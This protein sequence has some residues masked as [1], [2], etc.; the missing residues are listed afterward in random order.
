MNYSVNGAISQLF[1]IDIEELK[2]IT[3]CPKSYSSNDFKKRVL[4]SAKKELDNSEVTDLTFTYK[5]IKK[6]RSIS[7]FKIF[8]HHTKNDSLEVNKLS[9]QT[10]PK[11][12]F[13][14][15]I[16]QFLNRNKINFNGANRQLLM[17]FFKLNG[18]NK[19][20]ELLEN[21]KDLALRTSR[22]NPQGYIISAVKINIKQISEKKEEVRQKN[23]SSNQD[24]QTNIITQLAEL[25][26]RKTV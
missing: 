3:N 22:N 8:I 13:D 9:K 7:G 21:I 5:N 11:W 25:T 23:N 17:Q 12:D 6:G 20:L 26:K 2:F 19:G 15:E 24:S 4:D 16:I 10:S 18:V 1:Q 14:K